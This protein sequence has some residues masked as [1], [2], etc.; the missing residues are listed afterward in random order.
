MERILLGFAL[1]GFAGLVH[2]GPFVVSDALAPSSGGVAP[3]HCGYQI[4]GGTRADFPVATAGS[5]VICKVD[6]AGISNGKHD[7]NLTAVIVDAVWGRVES[8]P[9]ANFT[10]VK[11]GPSTAPTGIS[12]TK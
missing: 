3:T 1:V 9:S 7:V 11:P 10:F 8:P 4:D 5:T 12:L 2:A 6:L